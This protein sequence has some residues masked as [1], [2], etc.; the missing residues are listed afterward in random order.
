M[1]VNFGNGSANSVDPRR[2]QQYPSTAYYYPNRTVRRD[3]VNIS[4]PQQPR[5]QQ[6]RQQ[7]PYYQQMP[8]KVKKPSLQTVAMIASIGASI[9]IA[10]SFAAPHLASKF[11]KNNG[12][13]LFTKM[14][15][16]IPDIKD[17]NSVDKKAKSFL[18]R[19][20]DASKVSNEVWENAGKPAGDRSILLYGPPGTGKSFFAKVA[21]KSLDAQ[22]TEIDFSQIASPYVGQASKNIRDKA[23]AIIGDFNDYVE[24]NK[25]INLEGKI[26]EP[27]ELKF[28]EISDF[29]LIN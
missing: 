12:A 1:N 10:A 15:D 29:C 2:N 3:E 8:A 22:Y 24:N 7:K 28:F 17:L 16:D 23:D 26:E 9:A 18:S 11:A 25:K 27:K 19:I 4:D 6:S 21:A 5:V 14:G 20:I 13:K